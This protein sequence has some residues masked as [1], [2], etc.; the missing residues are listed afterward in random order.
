MPYEGPERINE[1]EQRGRVG[2]KSKISTLT[3]VG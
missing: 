1:R 3:D 2:E